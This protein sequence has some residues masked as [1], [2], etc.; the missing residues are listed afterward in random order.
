MWKFFAIQL[1]VVAT[2]WRG[3][4]STGTIDNS[5]SNKAI[6]IKYGKSMSNGLERYVRSIIINTRVI[7]YNLRASL[8][9]FILS[10]T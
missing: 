10:K 6:S 1:F 5:E 8:V 7:L 3:I 9:I 4:G 2:D